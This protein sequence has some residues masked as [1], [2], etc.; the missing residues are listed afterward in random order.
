MTAKTIAQRQAALR[1]RRAAEGLSEVRG[2]F[3]PPKQHAA[4]K[5][6]AK[7]LIKPA[8]PA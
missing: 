2:I 6:A 1:A 7:S 8:L 3:L 5:K 4:L